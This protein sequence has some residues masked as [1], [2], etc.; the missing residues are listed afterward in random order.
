M[1]TRVK[2]NRLRLVLILTIMLLISLETAFARDNAEKIT[3][4]TQIKTRENP[5]TGTPHRKIVMPGLE[6]KEGALLDE[7]IQPDSANESDQ[8]V[9]EDSCTSSAC[10][11]DIPQ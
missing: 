6:K 10:T 5:D 3:G 4:P 1:K 8:A 7:L 2:N 11:S 9:K